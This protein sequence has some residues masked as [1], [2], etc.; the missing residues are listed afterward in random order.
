MTPSMLFTVGFIFL[1]TIGGV[2]GVVLANAGLDVAFH[3]TYYVVAHFHYVLSMGAV[4]AI[5][6]GIYYWLS[7]I[8]GLSY[9]TVLA[10]IHF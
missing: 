8:I 1:F 3:D 2:T 10:E 6:A 4:F 5:F 7:K 9:D